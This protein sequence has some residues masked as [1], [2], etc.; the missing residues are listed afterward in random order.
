MKYTINIFQLFICIFCFLFIAHPLLSQVSPYGVFIPNGS[1]PSEI[2]SRVDAQIVDVRGLR[3]RDLAGASLSGVYAIRGKMNIGLSMPLVYSDFDGWLNDGL[4]DVALHLRYRLSR[5]FY[6]PRAIAIGADLL[7][8][9][10]NYELGNSYGQYIAAPYITFVYNT[11]EEFLIAPILRYYFGFDADP[12]VNRRS[13]LRFQLRSM[14]SYKNG[15]WTLLQPE[16]IFDFTGFNPTSLPLR[17]EIGKMFS[18]HWGASAEIIIYLA[19]K[20]RT[21][22]QAKINIRYLF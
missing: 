10:G 14:V 9:T 11:E 22:Y 20:E 4:G 12:G 13:E 3:N 18:L 8:K 19:G 21:N 5:P 17:T 1:D 16:A 2:R 6:A 7:L 15:F